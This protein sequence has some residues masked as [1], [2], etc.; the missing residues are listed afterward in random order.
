MWRRSRR[1]SSPRIERGPQGI[2]AIAGAP[3]ARHRESESPS[4]VP[5]L[6][7][8]AGWPLVQHCSVAEDRIRL[9]TI[10]ASAGRTGID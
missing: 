4:A 7:R 1:S 8:R 9:G 5:A 2:T 10:L 6:G 3:G